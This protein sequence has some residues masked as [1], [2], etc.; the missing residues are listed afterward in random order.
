MVFGTFGILS[1]ELGFVGIL[2]Q[3]AS[4]FNVTL[5]MAGLF[6]SGFSFVI[7]IGSLVIPLIVGKCNRKHLFV[8]V[9]L[10]MSIFSFAGGLTHNFYVALACRIISAFFYPAYISI[11]FTVAGELVDPVDAPRAVSKVV[12]GF[13]AGE[14]LGLPI[15]TFFVNHGGYPMAMFALGFLNLVSCIVTLLFFPSI[16][17][18]VDV[19]FKN[20]LKLSRKPI[21]ILSAIGVAVFS[22]GFC[23][24]YNYAASFLQIISHITGEFITFTLLLGGVMS[25]VGSWL[26]GRLLVKIPGKTVIVAPVVICINLALL[27][28]FATSG[29]MIFMIVLSALFGFFEGVF[30]NIIQYWIITAIPQAS[31]FAN[32]VFMSMLNVGVTLG[33]VIGGFLIADIGLMAIIP[34]SI[35]IILLSIILFASRM[36]KFSKTTS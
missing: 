29:N 13:S 30:T 11:A 9:L 2:P 18:H 25:I 22:T 36:Y 12:M 19:N 34:A 15:C 32:G 33:A 16:E 27:L 31:E 20:Q 17:G 23:L 26:T 28:L 5:D 7:M 3:I 24:Y 10:F 14:I 21:L 35:I 4:Y 6:I 8:L 1:T